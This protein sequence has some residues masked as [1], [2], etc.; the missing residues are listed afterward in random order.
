[1]EDGTIYSGRTVIFATGG[2]HRS[3][4]VPGV[5]EL[6]GKGVSYCAICDAPLFQKAGRPI[7]FYNKELKIMTE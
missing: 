6:V 4:S 7:Q 5:K 3:P 2:R 1:M